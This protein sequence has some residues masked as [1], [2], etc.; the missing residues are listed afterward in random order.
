MIAG[1]PASGVA[2]ALRSVQFAETDRP[3]DCLPRML[4]AASV[5]ALW[6]AT[7]G[8]GLIDHNVVAADT[9]GRIGHRVRALVPRRSRASG[10]LP[11]PGWTGEGEWDGMIPFEEMPAQVDPPGGVIVTANNRVVADGEPYL[12][13]DCHPPTAPPRIAKL[14]AE[15]P[16]YTVEDAATVHADTLS[17]HRD[18]FLQALRLA[19]PP[20]EEA[21]VV[22]EALLGW[23]GRM[24]A[25]STGATLYSA[26]RRA[27]TG[28]VVRRSG[29]DRAVSHRFAAVPPGI[30]PAG[31][32]WRT[33]PTLLRRD[34]TSLLESWTWANV[35]AA[36][37]GEVA[38]EPAVPWGEAHRPRFEHALPASMPE[39]ARLLDA[40]RFRSAAMAT[41]LWRSAFCQEWVRKRPLAHSAVTCST[42]A[43]GRTAAGP[44][45]RARRRIRAAR[46]APIGTRSG[47]DARWCRCA[48]I[49]ARSSAGRR[50]RSVSSRPERKR[51]DAGWLGSD[52]PCV[53]A[54][55][56]DP[57]R[58]SIVT[59]GA[60]SSRAADSSPNPSPCMRK[61][62]SVSV[63]SA[64]VTTFRRSHPRATIRLGMNRRMF[65]VSRR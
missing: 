55:A 13:T 44:C 42:W 34:D 33:L 65:A 8:W 36:A 43:R 64:S 15:R 21:A 37:L 1:D 50:A 38:G 25:G 20:S 22:R 39:N 12:C 49:G 27:M 3:C 56:G 30:S 61:L 41:P 47:A 51:L 18:L 23:D 29:L 40:R 16:H 53:P 32:V 58:A 52:E 4:A 10:W 2:L 6:E 45:S 11:V 19:V 31:Q 26:L 62:I 24:D 57:G 17:P 9:G 60:W 5:S 54:G 63:I 48:T 59:Y 46:T 28:I 14:V 7:R 35:V